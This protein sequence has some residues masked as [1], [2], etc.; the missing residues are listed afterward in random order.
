VWG[1]YEPVGK[2]DTRGYVEALELSRGRLCQLNWV[3][4]H[5]GS[6]RLVVGYGV[7][8]RGPALREKCDELQVL[9][10]QENGGTV[11]VCFTG[12]EYEEG[13][14]YLRFTSHPF[15]FGGLQEK[16]A[17]TC[18]DIAALLNPEERDSRVLEDHA[19]VLI[20]RKGPELT[21]L[22]RELLAQR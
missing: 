22:R 11:A 12:V 14:D 16:K 6:D 1:S 18:L 8:G 3:T 13:P 20:D 17:E 7:K 19:V 21:L 10:K 2:E 5:Q 4:T 15:E 9:F